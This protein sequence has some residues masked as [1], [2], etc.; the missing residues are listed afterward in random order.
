MSDSSDFGGILAEFKK[1]EEPENIVPLMDDE[2]LRNGLVAWKSVSIT[3]KKAESC[4]Y[5]D[6]NSRWN[7][8]WTMIEYDMTHFAIVAGVKPQDAVSLFRRLMGLRL[9]YPDGTINEFAKK[10]LQSLIMAKI[11]KS[12]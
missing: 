2:M 4:S 3:Y 12:T 11:K 9:I 1:I 8:L 10:Y 5:N 7:W 6:K